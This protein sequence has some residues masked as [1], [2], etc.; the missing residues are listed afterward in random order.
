MTDRSN[1]MTGFHSHTFTLLMTPQLIFYSILCWLLMSFQ[2][3]EDKQLQEELEL[4]VER[5]SVSFGL[6]SRRNIVHWVTQFVYMHTNNLIT[7]HIN[8]YYRLN[9]I[10]CCCV[11]LRSMWTISEPSRLFLKHSEAEQI[12]IELKYIWYIIYL[13]GFLSMIQLGFCSRSA[14]VVYPN[15][16][17]LYKLFSWLGKLIKKKKLSTRMFKDNWREKCNFFCKKKKKST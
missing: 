16:T 4:M 6:F 9:M 17:R 2:S 7:L 13:F 1:H 5:L 11:R 12:N 10:F 15:Y 8:Y 14:V 3:E